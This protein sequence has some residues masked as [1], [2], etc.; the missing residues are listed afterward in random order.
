M[1]SSL[2]ECAKR[3]Y[4]GVPQVNYV[5]VY[6]P[7]TRFC[8]H[9]FKLSIVH[10]LARKS[11][12]PALRHCSSKWSA[13]C[14]VINITGALGCE[15]SSDRKQIR[16]V[17]SVPSITGMCM[18]M[19]TTSKGSFSSRSTAFAPLSTTVQFLIQARQNTRQYLLIDQVVLCDKNSQC[20]NIDSS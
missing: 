12:A 6:L 1:A 19:S 10:G 17:A 11:I 3:N 4:G 13:T 7:K 16:F 14:A 18:S 5:L 9:F 20:L 8:K 15:P 2:P